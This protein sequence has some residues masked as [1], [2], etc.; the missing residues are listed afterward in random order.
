LVLVAG[1]WA[2]L[3]TPLAGRGQ[4]VAGNFFIK[5]IEQTLPRPKDFAKSKNG[6]ISVVFCTA[7]ETLR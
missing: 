3:E 4:G 6:Y 5:Y 7:K 1:R 2:A